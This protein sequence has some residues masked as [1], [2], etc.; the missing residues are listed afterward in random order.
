MRHLIDWLSDRKDYTNRV[1]AYHISE[2]LVL[3]IQNI[4]HSGQEQKSLRVCWL[5]TCNNLYDSQARTQWSTDILTS[6][7]AN[8]LQILMREYL[9]M[10]NPRTPFRK[11]GPIL[12][13]NFLIYV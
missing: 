6:E 10:F 2:V 8:P 5:H 4:I 12:I 1:S 13:K 11:I 3:E 9:C 7:F